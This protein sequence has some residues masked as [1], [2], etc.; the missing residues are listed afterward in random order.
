MANLT[1]ATIKIATK[2]D[3]NNVFI[4]SFLKKLAAEKTLSLRK[5]YLI[6]K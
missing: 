4:F 2:E 6:K 1:F 3:V 5:H